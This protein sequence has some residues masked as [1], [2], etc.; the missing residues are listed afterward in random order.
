VGAN[1]PPLAPARGIVSIRVYLD[2][3]SLS[4]PAGKGTGVGEV[5]SNF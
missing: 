5:S 3:S 4:L 2:R 1:P